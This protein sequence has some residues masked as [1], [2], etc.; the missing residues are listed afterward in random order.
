MK[1]EFIA[2]NGD[3]FK[4]CTKCKKAYG[5]HS[6]DGL[7]EF[8]YRDGHRAD[9]LMNDCK[10]CCRKRKRKPETNRRI[11]KRKYERYPEQIL[12]G[13]KFRAAI[14]AG[15]IKRQSVC[16]KCDSNFK[17]EGHH[18]DYSKPLEVMWLCKYCHNAEHAKMKRAPNEHAS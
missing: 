17:V 13:N 9:G 18:P 12:A 4:D 10:A 15:K 3:W 1:A 11:A 2:F 14:K 8:F 16:E 7:T 5:A 6:K